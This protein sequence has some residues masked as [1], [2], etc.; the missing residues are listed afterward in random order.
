MLKHVMLTIDLTAL[1]VSHSSPRFMK[2][3]KIR[4]EIKDSVLIIQQ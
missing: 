2:I 1:R 3:C 4:G